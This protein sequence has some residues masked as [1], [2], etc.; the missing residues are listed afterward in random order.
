MLG[1]ERTRRWAEEY[2]ARMSYW[3]RN[4]EREY[5]ELLVT[6]R[7]A[8]NGGRGTSGGLSGAVPSNRGFPVS[9]LLD[10][11]APHRCL[12]TGP[13]GCGKSTSCM[14]L[15]QRAL[16]RFV[17]GETDTIAVLL[18]GHG[19]SSTADDFAGQIA[20]SVA[21]LAQT[22]MTETLNVA[23]QTGRLMVFLDGFDELRRDMHEAQARAVEEW[24]FRYPRSRCV[25]TSRTLDTP[26]L[27]DFR[28]YDFAALGERQVEQ[29]VRLRLPPKEAEAFLLDIGQRQ[30]RSVLLSSPFLL[31]QLIEAYR[32][33]GGLP[34]ASS[35]TFASLVNGAFSQGIQPDKRVPMTAL[36]TQFAKR[37][38][39]AGRVVASQEV[40][41]DVIA[42]NRHL[43]GAWSDGASV[44][45]SL[46]RTGVLRQEEHGVSF[47]HAALLEHFAGSDLGPIDDVWKPPDAIS[48]GTIEIVRFIDQELL[49]RLARQPADLYRLSPRDFEKV[50]AELFRD[51][52]WKVELTKQTRDGGSDIIAVRS[53]MGAHIQMLI[54]AKRYG[55]DKTIGV[56]IVRQLYAVRQLRHASKAILATTSHF[57]PDVFR[58][59]ASVIPWELELSDYNE[60]LKW[61]NAYGRSG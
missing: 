20:Q 46:L 35:L 21:D 18:H 10:E 49:K 34:D 43:L 51:K 12:L 61:L 16:S 39:T 8:G 6:A 30:D 58:E 29:F 2:A 31:A 50:I 37:L 59:F 44:M 17:A 4:L 38:R 14:F 7:E 32:T 26:R 25:V 15:V 27:R 48:P 41:N 24:T 11:Q 13:P 55:P 5:V 40:V 22:D 42:S 33:L 1:G 36:L 56:G 47:L 52:G 54:E 9:Y 3:G 19:I 53:D 23:A 45:D 28:I 60:I 57:S